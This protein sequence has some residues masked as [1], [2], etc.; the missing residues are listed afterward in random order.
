MWRKLTG[1]ITKEPEDSERMPGQDVSD[2]PTP[3][4]KKFIAALAMRS[5]G[6]G[7]GEGGKGTERRLLARLEWNIRL[8]FADGAMSCVRLSA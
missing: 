1:N 4:K 7:P 5:I 6:T 8:D 2:V 3:V